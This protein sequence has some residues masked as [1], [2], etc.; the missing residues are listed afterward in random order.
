[1][2]L[3]DLTIVPAEGTWVVRAGGAVIGESAR[4][5]EVAEGD[6]R[7]VIY[8]PRADLGMAFLERSPTTASSRTLG[9]ARYF[10][11]VTRSGVIADAAWS[12]EA[13]RDGA[14]RIAGHIAFDHRL[15][16][17]EGV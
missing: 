10:S 12:Y 15:V 4:A 13:P 9:D 1:M 14:G 7:P 5:L 17:V 6:G 3:S 11:I 8:F 16:A 2:P